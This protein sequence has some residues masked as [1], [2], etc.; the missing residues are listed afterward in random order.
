MDASLWK[1]PS[2]LADKE[3]PMLKF[4]DM[5]VICLGITLVKYLVGR[6]LISDLRL[7]LLNLPVVMKGTYS[8]G[9]RRTL[10]HYVPWH[11]QEQPH[12]DKSGLRFP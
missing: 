3:G 11:G 8:L 2:I 9:N 6:Y 5:Y 10:K 1:L 7:T 4:Q 12:G